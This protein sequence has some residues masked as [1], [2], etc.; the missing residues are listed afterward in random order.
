VA[1]KQSQ[2]PATTHQHQNGSVEEPEAAARSAGLRYV[3]DAEPGIRRVRAGRGFRYLDPEGKPIRDERTLKRIKALVIPPAWTDVW[4]SPWPRGHIQATGRDS[5]GRKQY[6]YHQKWREVRDETK[7]GRLVDFATAL[8][9]MRERISSDLARH[10]LPREKVLAAIVALLERTLVRV[11]NEEYARANRSY[12]L[13][14]LRDRHVDVN[15]S[16]LHF[17]FRGKSGVEHEVDLHD[18]RLAGIVKRCRDLPGQHLFQY[19][20]A[21]GQRHPITSTDVNDYLRD[22]SGG[23][24]TAKDLRTWAGTLLACEELVNAE[25]PTSETAGQHQIVQAVDAVARQLGNTRAVCRRCYI[26]PA[27][28]DAYLAGTLPASFPKSNG[29]EPDT[30]TTD[31]SPDE[32][33]ML[34]FL[35]SLDTNGK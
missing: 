5:A 32:A 16:S 14:T 4:I 12:G 27:V 7:Y 9:A 10:D 15:T 3:T 20:D 30:S 1:G 11:G 18:R 19:V 26:H 25:P 2:G 29:R 22:I 33:A 34:R 23:D 24:F 31:L 28:I 6:R 8:P 35:K 21:E 13:T 17:H